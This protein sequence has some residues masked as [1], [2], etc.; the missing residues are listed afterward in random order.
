MDPSLTFFAVDP[1]LFISAFIAGF[2]MFLAPCTLP[3]LPGYLGYISGLTHVELTDP[4]PGNGVRRR[5]LKHAGAFVSGFTVVFVGLGLLAGFAGSLVAP[6]RAVLTV[7][8]GTF[9]FLSGLFLIGVFRIPFLMRAQQMSLPSVLKRGTPYASFLLGAAF[10]FGWSPCIGPILGT[11]LFFAGNSET[12]AI[13]AF[14]LLTFSL[15]FAL[16]FLVLAFAIEQV[17][18]Y[19]QKVTP[20]LR[21][22]S[23][24]GGVVLLILG[25]RLMVGATPL[26]DWFIDLFHPFDALEYLYPYL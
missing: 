8:G 10:A 25:V 6:A 11:V 24:G 23:I 19:I 1:F 5:L 20:F 7:L 14:L 3:I 4:T 26:T 21:M 16:P 15:G 17:G 2:L 12:I 18:E 9:I 13:G 22:V